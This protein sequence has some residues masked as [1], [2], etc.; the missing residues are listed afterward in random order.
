MLFPSDFSFL[1]SYTGKVTL[2]IFIYSLSDSKIFSWIMMEDN[3]FNLNNHTN[4][5][6]EISKAASKFR[7]DDG[8][9][10]QGDSVRNRNSRQRPRN[11]NNNSNRNNN[12]NNHNHQHNRPSDSIDADINK[13][14]PPDVDSS[15]D[16]AEVESHNYCLVCYSDDISCNRTITPCESSSNALPF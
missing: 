8:R 9:Q 10:K 3:E 5:D 2:L 1:S 15:T 11:R 6:D 14:S 7:K 16:D 13:I 12:N 4:V